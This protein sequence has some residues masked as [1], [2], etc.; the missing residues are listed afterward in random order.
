MRRLRLIVICALVFCLVLCI[1]ALNFP[2]AVP[3]FASHK[4][5]EVYLL[6]ASSGSLPQLL[7]TGQIDAF[8]I[9]EPIVSN[10]ELSGIGKRIAVPADL[11]PPGKWNN[12]A[13]N[14]MIL[15]KDTIAEYPDATALLS[16]F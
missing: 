2:D 10:A 4:T 7:N 6:Y 15:R 1:I 16:A 5:P 3:G 13:I 11:P 14:V 9:W 8:L 12:A